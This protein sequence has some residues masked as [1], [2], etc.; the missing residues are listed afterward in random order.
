MSLR[1]RPVI[2]LHDVRPVS[3][4]AGPCPERAD[5]GA[6]QDAVRLEGEAEHLGAAWML[7]GRQ[8][9]AGLHDGH[10]DAEPGVDLR[11][12]TPGRPTAEHQ[13]GSWQ[14][15]GERRLAVRPGPGPG[16][17]FDRRELGRRTH[18]D[19]DVPR[20]QLLGCARMGD[21]HHATAR[22]PALAAPD[23]R[24]GGLECPDVRAV[25]RLSRAGG[26]VDHVVAAG[27]C[28]GPRVVL[29]RRVTVRGVEQALGRDAAD[30]RTGAPEP[31]PVD[32][33][34]RRAHGPR[35]VRRCFAGRAGPDHHEVERAHSGY[36]HKDV[37]RSRAGGAPRRGGWR[38]RSTR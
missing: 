36:R 25:V 20:A 12:L 19:D 22:D 6:H 26:P 34:H 18:C 21:R 24:P 29:A 38:L 31:L 7:G 14:L 30:V 32:D 2:E 23:N 5:A 4:G 9:G 28:P 8:A 10:R 1:G 37:K 17:P 3:A 13:Q 27:R 15:P 16:E 35:L 11:E 33:G